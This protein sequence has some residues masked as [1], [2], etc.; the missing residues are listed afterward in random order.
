MTKAKLL[1]NPVLRNKVESN[2]SNPV[3]D[4]SREI[5]EQDLNGETGGNSI[6]I[7]VTTMPTVTIVP[8]VITIGLCLPT[9]TVGAVCR[10]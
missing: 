5:A 6:I 4:I 1:K 9:T 7:T 2:V 8:P 10:L 3:G